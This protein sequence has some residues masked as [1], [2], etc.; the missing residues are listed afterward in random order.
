MG[1]SACTLPAEA[2]SDYIRQ[3]KDVADAVNSL[4]WMIQDMTPEEE[5]RLT[6]YLQSSLVR[7]SDGWKLPYSRVIRWAVLWWDKE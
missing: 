2:I 1:H 7:N 3:F 5:A 6:R 4:Q